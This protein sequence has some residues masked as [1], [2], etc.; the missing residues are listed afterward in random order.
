MC[1]GITCS[2]LNGRCVWARFLPY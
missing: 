2:I 1:G